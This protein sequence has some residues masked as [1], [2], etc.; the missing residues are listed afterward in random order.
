MTSDAPLPVVRPVAPASR[1]AGAPPP[2]TASRVP[3]VVALVLGAC[4]LAF[5][6][7][8]V[9]S[10]P[11]PKEKEWGKSRFGEGTRA[12]LERLRDRLAAGLVSLRLPGGD[13]SP[14]FFDSRQDEGMVRRQTT[15]VAVAGLAAAKRMEAHAKGLDEALADAKAVLTNRKAGSG[16]GASSVKPDRARTDATLAAGV[17]GLLW[18]RD[19]ADESRLSIATWALVAE[20]R[21]GPMGKGWP[22]GI[23]TRA[24]AA[25]F[26]DGRADLLG[27]DPQTLVQVDPVLDAKL[28]CGDPRISDA[29]ARA[30]ARTP[31]AEERGKAVLAECMKPDVLEWDGDGTDLSTWT[32]TAW[33]A[34]RVPGGD[35]WFGKAL[36][37][38]EKA[39]D[40]A[41]VIQGTRYG[42]PVSRTAEAL[43][44]L[45]EGWEPPPAGAP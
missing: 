10:P 23:A 27:N 8:A 31:D 19:P 21:I 18:A 32:L 16:G 15:A 42:D 30:V 4:V 37:L 20:S 45:F 12:R 43:W 17:L 38:L 33:L 36:P 29:F 7:L 2:R 34:A 9:V 35:A 41:G 39:P 5:S 3:F 24:F 11:K 13:Y 44:I 6:V 25:L 14:G 40:E 28:D 1:E 22:R 26:E